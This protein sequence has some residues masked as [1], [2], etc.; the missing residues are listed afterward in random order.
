MSAIVQSS[1]EQGIIWL[2][3][4]SMVDYAG[5]HEGLWCTRTENPSIYTW[6]RKVGCMSN[7]YLMINWINHVCFKI[8]DIFPPQCTPFSEGLCILLNIKLN[9]KSRINISIKYKTQTFFYC[10]YFC[11][12]L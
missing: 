7:W 10:K 4:S 6:V 9:I 5:V 2:V 11:G 1:N 3:D 12:K 8:L